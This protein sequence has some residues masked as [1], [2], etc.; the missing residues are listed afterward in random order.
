MPIVSSVP[1]V[2]ASLAVR[3]PIFTENAPGPLSSM[4]LPLFPAACVN[5]AWIASTAACCAPGS[6]PAARVCTS[7]SAWVPVWSNQTSSMRCGAVAGCSASATRRSCRVGSEGSNGS[8][9]PPAGEPRSCNRACSSSPSV[10]RENA[11]A[12]SAWIR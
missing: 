8:I 11:S 10:A 4:R 12:G 1:M 5:A 9:R 7:S 6:K 2:L 3:L